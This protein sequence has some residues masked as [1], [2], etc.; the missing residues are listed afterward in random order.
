VKTL[1]ADNPSDLL[2]LS[3][4]IKSAG[5]S[6]ET[7]RYYNTRSLDVIKNH[8]Y[9][10]LILKDDFPVAYGHLDKEENRI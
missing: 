1:S 7:F 9:T 2:L 4:F 5:N 6:L 10:I 8:L 3:K